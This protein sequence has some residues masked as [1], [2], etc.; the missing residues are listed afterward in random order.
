MLEILRKVWNFVKEK[1]IN[2]YM[3][4][5]KKKKYSIRMIPCMRKCNEIE[6]IV[7][8]MV[9][10]EMHLETMI[11]LGNKN[12]SY[13][14]TWLDE[15]DA[16]SKKEIEQKNTKIKYYIWLLFKFY[17]EVCCSEDVLFSKE[18]EEK[19]HRTIINRGYDTR[20]TQFTTC[21]NFSISVIL[22]FYTFQNSFLYLFLALSQRI[23]IL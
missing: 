6:E 19:F 20:G 17:A 10:C 7:I 22:A 13:C 18:E 16:C 3:M 12:C 21:L 23:Y 5:K 9:K 1:T 8:K 11:H 15:Q 14:R 2:G 4:K